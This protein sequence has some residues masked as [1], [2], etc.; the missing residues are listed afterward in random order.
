MAIRAPDGANKTF[1]VC[2][3]FSPEYEKSLLSDK[4]KCSCKT[5]TRIMFQKKMKHHRFVKSYS[6][7][8]NDYIN[9][10]IFSLFDRQLDSSAATKPIED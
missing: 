8:S 5:N 3:N 1:L 10:S 6:N 7:F 9:R 4:F 2:Q